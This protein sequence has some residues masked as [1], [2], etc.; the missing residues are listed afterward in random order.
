M[1]TLDNL[2]RSQ[3]E[4]FALVK[5]FPLLREYARPGGSW[6]VSLWKFLGELPAASDLP[7]FIPSADME[8]MPPS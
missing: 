2:A 8:L 7:V 6:E 3:P 1:T 4:N 5:T